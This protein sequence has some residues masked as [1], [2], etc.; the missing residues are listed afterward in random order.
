MRKLYALAVCLAVMLVGGAVCLSGRVATA[1]PEVRVA[2]GKLEGMQLGSGEALAFLGVPYAAPPVGELRWKP[3]E[4]SKNWRGTRKATAFGPVCPQ[5]PQ[6]WL[7]YIAGQEDCLY[8]NVWTTRLATSAKLPVIVYFY[9][10]GNVAGY[11]QF[12]PLGPAFVRLGV[13]VVTANYRLGPFGFLAHPA[14]SA[15]SPHH[16]SGNY[17]LLDQIQALRW[18]KENI[19]QFGGDPEYVTIMGQS[20][21]AVDVCMLMASPL[22]KDLFRGAILQSG[23][24][25]STLLEDIRKP[26]HYNFIEDTGEAMGERLASDL[27]VESGRNVLAQLRRIPADSILKAW[28]QDSRMHFEVLVDGWVVP[29]QPAKIFADGK[30]MHIPIL[31]GSNADEATVFGDGGIKTVDQY[32]KYLQ[33]DTGKWADQEFATYPVNSDAEVH[34]RW[35]QF[36][37][38]EFAYG[39]YSMAQAVTRAGQRAYLYTFTFGETGKAAALGA[40]HGLELNFLCDSF[41]PQWEHSA[42][43][44]KLGEA[45]RG[46][47]TQFAKAGD[48]NHEGVP[49]WPAF[50]LAAE[51]ALELG[52]EIRP[53]TIEPR[54]RVMQRLTQLTIQEGVNTEAGK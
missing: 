36:Q 23:E 7:P 15:E 2:Q 31:V 44:R 6:D 13:V 4:P 20:A 19:A 10:G 1:P 29:E 48:P 46:Y 54:L 14:L 49:M 16:S 45:M 25:Q 11:S 27:K 21:G 24:C 41:P 40:H 42:A 52:H 8:L 50:D 51:Q 12:T 32:K 3:P 38:D 37:S 34:A 28:S 18:V 22:A 26:L 47:W 39:A 30:Q 9:G 53:G 43:E 33:K 5:L 35:V 17:G